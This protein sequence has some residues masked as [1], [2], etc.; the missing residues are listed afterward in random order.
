MYVKCM[1]WTNK[2]NKTKLQ[3]F[4]G[5]LPYSMGLHSLLLKK[6]L[7]K[8]N[9]RFRKKEIFPI[10][11]IPHLTYPKLNLLVSQ[12]VK[13]NRE[14]TL[15]N[16]ESTQVYFWSLLPNPSNLG[17]TLAMIMF[18]GGMSSLKPLEFLQT[19]YILPVF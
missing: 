8:F 4:R 7:E 19:T 6:D 16:F 15:T 10:H 17:T 18:M 11:G 1:Y 13:G 9:T 12:C 5:Y 2:Q 3:S 14:S